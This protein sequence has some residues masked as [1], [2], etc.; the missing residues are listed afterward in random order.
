M[1]RA[2]EESTFSASKASADSCAT[3]QFF[4]LISHS[5]DFTTHAKLT[6]AKPRSRS[7]GTLVL[8]GV[9]EI[10]ALVRAHAVDLRRRPRHAVAVRVDVSLVAGQDFPKLRRR[11]RGPRQVAYCWAWRGGW[12]RWCGTCVSALLRCHGC[13]ASR[14]HG[15]RSA[16]WRIWV[17]LAV[18]TSGFGGQ[19][20]AALVTNVCGLLSVAVRSSWRAGQ[21]DDPVYNHS[22]RSPLAETV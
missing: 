21:T 17:P 10:V 13:H 12:R 22:V 4:A 15:E 9:V 2:P 19:S 20:L 3:S 16:G 14:C 18:A 1:A 8:R 11:G 7:S 5:D 6:P